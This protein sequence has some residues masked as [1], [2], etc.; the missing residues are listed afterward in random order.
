MF[1]ARRQVNSHSVQEKANAHWRSNIQQMDKNI[2]LAALY[3]EML[4]LTYKNSE[5]DQLLN[6]N[7]GNMKCKLEPVLA[8]NIDL[9]HYI[10]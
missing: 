1:R 3:A 4:H 7:L 8:L 5:L 9:F 10:Y 6:I 2:H